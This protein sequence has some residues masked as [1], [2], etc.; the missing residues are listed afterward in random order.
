MRQNRIT[1]IF[2]LFILF[3]ILLQIRII[4][5]SIF[6]DP[7]L[8]NMAA[9]PSTRGSI[10][11]RNSRELAV[12]S[13]FYS[14]YARPKLMTAARRHDFYN[15]LAVSADL[16]NGMQLL[17]SDKNFVWLKR[18]MTPGESAGIREIV[19]DMKKSNLIV[20]DEIGV[21][22][23]EG[24]F[25]TSAASTHVVGVVGIDNT[26]LSGLEL[27][28]NG[29]LAKGYSVYTTLDSELSAIVFEEL[30]KGI[31]ENQAEYGSA[32]IID[33]SSME[34]LSIVNFPSYDPNDLKSITTFNLQSKANSSIFEPGSVMKQ[35]SA[36]FALEK[37]YATPSY[38]VYD[39]PGYA[40]IDEQTFSCE[41]PH[42]K[43]DLTS[44]IQ[45]SCNVGMVQVAD[46]FKKHEFYEFLRNFG[47]GE[48]LPLPLL[49]NSSGIL[50]TPDRWSALSKYMI[51]IGQEI[52]VNALQLS[53]ASSVIA[54]DGVYRMPVLIRGITDERGNN[55]YRPGFKSFRVISSETSRELLSMM[56]RVV[57]ENGTAIKAK[58]EGVTI[59]G[60]TGTGQ[61]AKEKG[62]GY[63]KDLFNA[64]F[65]GYVPSV[66]PRYTVVVVISKS[67]G[68]YH[69]GGLVAAP[70]FANIIRRMI[71]STSY[72]TNE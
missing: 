70:V 36:A 18:K 37:K 50:R 67:H 13:A 66:R 24:R 43:V 64:V 17:E 71:T 3:F 39:C 6:P 7:R 72:F 25:Y 12:S 46:N 47:F 29:Y 14:L 15:L 33:N 16:S 57:S 35:F 49:E 56:E 26:G 40:T 61:I 1:V 32:I 41:N 38:P 59:A 21:I 30:K 53:I 65:I 51:A 52:G 58:I 60:K 54:G 48:S 4:S 2:F 20:H 63:Y 27:S 44:I 10:I 31:I 23:E 19:S 28:M 68:D 42:G 34:L 55:I 45:K 11:D 62:Q 69:T 9:V 8:K 22:T 5:I